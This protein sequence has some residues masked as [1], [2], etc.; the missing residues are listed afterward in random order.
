MESVARGRPQRFHARVVLEG[1]RLQ[2]QQHLYL[3]GTFRRNS[4]RKFEMRAGRPASA[5]LADRRPPPASCRRATGPHLVRGWSTPA[6]H[7]EIERPA[8]CRCG[9]GGRR[10]RPHHEPHPG[11]EH[12]G[13]SDGD[14]PARTRRGRCRPSIG[15]GA[16]RAVE[17]V[18]LNADIPDVARALSHILREAALDDGPKRR[19]NISGQR[20]AIGL[21]AQHAGQ[22][23]AHV[24]AFARDRPRPCRRH[25]AATRPR[26]DRACD[27]QRGTFRGGRIIAKLAWGAGGL[28]FCD[29][30]VF[31]ERFHG[32][33]AVGRRGRDLRALRLGARGVPA[34][35]GVVVSE[36]ASL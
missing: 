18:E 22:R 5:G 35:A 25:R 10:A 29:A 7:F 4:S 23:P 15:V 32:L 17:L 9:A 24:L 3:A 19:R 33:P 30:E 11:Q 13:G 27:L 34:T 2:P 1:S 26:T 36:P 6:R 21:R 8:H 12:S 31:S 16:R 20:R 14:G 28:G